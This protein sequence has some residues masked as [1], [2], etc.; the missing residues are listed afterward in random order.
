MNVILAEGQNKQYSTYGIGVLKTCVDQMDTMATLR[1]HLPGDI[2]AFTSRRD[3]RPDIKG[4]QL[5]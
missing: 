1:V 4:T 5:R 3:T 2:L